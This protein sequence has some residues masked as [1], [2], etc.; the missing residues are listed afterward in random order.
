M[1]QKGTLLCGKSTVLGLAQDAFA[2]AGVF[3]RETFYSDLSRFYFRI[4]LVLFFGF[5]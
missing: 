1:I 2:Q 3:F 5:L 4:F